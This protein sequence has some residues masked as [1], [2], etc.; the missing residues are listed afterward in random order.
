MFDASAGADIER[1]SRRGLSKISLDA[2]IPPQRIGPAQAKRE[3]VR[4][5]FEL[6]Q[7]AQ[8]ATGLRWFLCPQSLA[9]GLLSIRAS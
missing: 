8:A 4:A 1:R 9:S 5:C 6:S 3:W 7:S 2:S